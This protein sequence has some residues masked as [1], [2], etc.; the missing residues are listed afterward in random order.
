MKAVPKK[1]AAEALA[2]GI[3][4]HQA[5][6][7]AAAEPFYQ[8]VL[9]LEPH[10]AQALYLL[11]ALYY[12]LGKF[13]QA[14][15][16]L[17]RSIALQPAD[18]ATQAILGVVYAKLKQFDR[19]L[20]YLRSV[21]SSSPTSSTA[22]F[23]LGRAL[24]D[25]GAHQEALGA[26]ERA[27]ALNP[28]Y[29]EA[30]DSIAVCHT[31]EGRLDIAEKTLKACV[32]S[33]PHFMK[34]FI[35]LGQLL[36]R[37]GR[38][39]EVV[40][41]FDACLAHHPRSVECLQL[42][43]GLHY[44]KGNLTEAEKLF[45]RL[46]ALLPD[47]PIAN[48][49][50]GA[51]L[52]DLSKIDEA[53]VMIRKSYRLRPGDNEVVTNMGLLLL[54]KGQLTEAAA[55]HREAIRL[56]PTMAEAWNNL[57]IALQH[58]HEFDEALSCYDK[59]IAL[60]PTFLGAGTNKAQA[61]LILGRMAEGWPVY[62]NRFDQKIH[63]SKRRAFDLPTWDGIAHS[64]SKVL[65]WTDQGLGDEILYSSMIPDIQSRS[66]GCMLECSTRMVSLFQRSFPDVRVVPR[67][68][69]PVA[70]IDSFA[71]DA[72]LSLVQAGEFLRPDI[73]SIPSHSGYLRAH[74]EGIRELKVKY[75]ALAAG[76][77]IVG[78][79]WKSENPRTAHF[80]SIP[81][82]QWLPILK[83]PNVFFISLQYGEQAREI[84]EINAVLD[85]GIHRDLDIDPI[86][87]P[88]HF[89]AQVAAMDLVLTTSNTT[90]HFAGALNVPVWTMVPKGPGSLWYWF[91]NRDDSPWYPSMR[92]FRQ[93]RTADWSEVVSRVADRLGQWHGA[94]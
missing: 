82:A 40:E 36:L 83:T 61:L 66:A 84:D 55:M 60:K 44:R 76:R 35:A 48:C 75:T 57:G 93:P 85:H 67:R 20:S 27:Y 74:P 1:T 13:D 3:Q 49:Y 51:V 43:G 69:P 23:N 47:D 58:L 30:L 39:V 15:D 87:Q 17:E 16:K 70:D 89:A 4:A 19:A 72:Q 26:F 81:L 42:Y 22:Q 91:L 65:L 56:K 33:F 59:A 88:D 5:G 78:I 77:R 25:I 12:E 94:R 21:A 92:L 7:R 50:L 11:G 28:N 45:R 53:E 46:L 90:A 73:A 38:D 64:K 10:N 34:A 31:A 2:A 18:L 14:R 24:C 37:Q 41:V 63:A 29:V 80:K 54:E 32:S 9:L 68:T 62:R 6:Q 79:S 52:M 86:R 8:H 71:P